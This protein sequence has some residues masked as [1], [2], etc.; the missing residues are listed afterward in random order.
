MAALSYPRLAI[1]ICGLT[2]PQQALAC[3]Q[4]GADAIGLVFY[5]PSPRHVG[6]DLAGEICKILPAGVAKVGVFVDA[7]I[8]DILAKV[9]HCGLTA[10]QLHGNE[11]PALAKALVRRDLK[12]IKAVFAARP[13][14]LTEAATFAPTAFLV[15]CG[16]GD[17]PGGNAEQW[18]WAGSAAVPRPFV[19]AG[20]LS[21][22]NVAEAIAA[23]RPDGVDVSSGV[24]TTP[25]DKDL[26]AVTAFI[27][28]ARL[29]QSRIADW[30]PVPIF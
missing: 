17:L 28:N 14:F 1:K 18:D 27:Q 29:A 22:R 3:A 7:P 15:E 8:Q 12:V 20:G 11:A 13:P 10:V 21:P 25:G 16:R 2:K 24:E 5:P 6:D 30:Q 4:A 19:L 26:A 23:A 9:V